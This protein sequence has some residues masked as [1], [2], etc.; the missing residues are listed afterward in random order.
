MGLEG[1]RDNFTASLDKTQVG[2]TSNMKKLYDLIKK[3]DAQVYQVLEKQNL[4][5]EFF[6]FRWLTLLLSQD[7]KL[8]GKFIYI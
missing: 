2:I 1:V 3:N 7:F 8:P 6:A 4:K 5:P